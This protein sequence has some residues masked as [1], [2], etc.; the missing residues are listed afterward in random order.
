MKNGESRDAKKT[1]GREKNL[2]SCNYSLIKILPFK[3]FFFSSSNVYYKKKRIKDR[4]AVV[5]TSLFS[6]EYE[7]L[8]FESF[9]LGFCGSVFADVF[10]DVPKEILKYG[11]S[12]DNFDQI[13]WESREWIPINVA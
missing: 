5:K 4:V 2:F 12:A 8:L 6:L 10:L 13:E 9:R 7:V 11:V 3:L 1:I